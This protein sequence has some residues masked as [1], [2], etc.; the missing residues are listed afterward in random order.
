M[1]VWSFDGSIWIV[2]IVWCLGFFYYVLFLLS[3]WHL[4]VSSDFLFSSVLF[5]LLRWSTFK[6][7]SIFSPFPNFL[8]SSNNFSA[9]SFINYSLFITSWFLVCSI[10]ELP[11]CF[12][13]S[14]FFPRVLES[15]IPSFS[16]SFLR[17]CKVSG[18]LDRSSYCIHWILY[19]GGDTL[20]HLGQNW[21]DR[22]DIA[23]R[24]NLVI[25][26]CGS[27]F[28]IHCRMFGSLE[29]C[30]RGNSKIFLV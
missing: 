4:S 25:R 21:Y 20:R 11:L 28:N 8:I 12:L 17:S 29:R 15:F 22:V 3:Y 18:F 7:F 27:A 16:K 9:Y 10:L 2:L 26:H 30:R 1:L 5:N 6:P 24:Y 13:S 23:T 14:N 19:N